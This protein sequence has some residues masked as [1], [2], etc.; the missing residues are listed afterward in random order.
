VPAVEWED[1]GRLGVGRARVGE[2]AE[3]LDCKGAQMKPTGFDPVNLPLDWPKPWSANWIMF[4]WMGPDW[5][6]ACSSSGEHTSKFCF[7][8]PSPNPFDAAPE[9]EQ[10]LGHH[11]GQRAGNAAQEQERVAQPGFFVNKLA[12]VLV[13]EVVHDQSHLP[14]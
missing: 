3:G 10:M 9:G 7:S 8:S 12:H 2:V 1:F 11:R 13:E 14:I 6:K 5:K 4:S